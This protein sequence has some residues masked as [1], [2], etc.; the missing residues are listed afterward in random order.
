[1]VFRCRECN[2][3]LTPGLVEGLVASVADGEAHV[4]PGEFARLDDGFW[5]H[6]AGWFAVHLDDGHAMPRYALPGRM[7]GCCGPAGCDG[8]N[9]VCRNGH[10]VA[11][12]KSDCWM[13]H[14]I[15]LDPARV[16]LA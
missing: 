13:P 6:H 2:V 16:D 8:N 7:S 1:M 4:R 5:T 12:E 9:R 3:T 11:T 14:A 15:L 10:E